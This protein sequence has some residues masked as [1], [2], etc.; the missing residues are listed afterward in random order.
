MPSS[1]PDRVLGSALDCSRRG[2]L[3]ESLATLVGLLAG[4]NTAWA[5]ARSPRAGLLGFA[6]IPPS[7]IDDVVLPPGYVYDI[8][9]A[10]GDPIVPSGPKYDPTARSSAADQARQVGMEHDGM[11]FFPL[12][13]AGTRGLLVVNHEGEDD[14]L[15]HAKGR[16]DWTLEQ[17]RKGQAAVGVS[18]VEIERNGTT[19]KWAVVESPLA[20]RLTANTECELTGPARGAAPVKSPQ[21]PEGDRS[22]G[23]LANCAHGVTPWG[24]YLT[25]EENFHEYYTHSGA[26][27]EMERRYG[28]GDKLI[29]NWHHGDDRFDAAKSPWSANTF[30]WV[31][32]FDP[33]RPDLAP[34]KRTA[35][36][37]FRHENCAITLA[38]DGRVVAYMG[39]DAR[40]EYLYK[41]VSE[42]AG[43]AGQDAYLDSPLD[44]GT[45]YVAR[46][47]GNDVGEWIPLVHGQ[48]GLDA[49]HGFRDQA[50]VCIFA[51][52]AA[53]L[54]LGDDGV[55][56]GTRLDRPEWVAIH[57]KRGEVF[58]SLTNNHER[59]MPGAPDK[60]V[61]AANPRAANQMG[62]IVRFTESEGDAAS[63]HFRW[64]HFLLAGDR[65]HPDPAR[66]G[67]I[68]SSRADQDFAS[69]DGLWVDPRGVLWIQTDVSTDIVGRGDQ[70]PFGNN[71]MLAAD[72]ATGEVRRFLVGPRGCEVT[73]VTCSPD[74]TTLFVNIQHPGQAPNDQ[75]NDPRHVDL[76]SSWPTL[77][78]G[79]RPR[80]ATLAIRRLD[81]GVV[82]AG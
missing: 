30:G 41:F 52:R 32:E 8:V 9:H 44:R 50:D 82:G 79:S 62:Q 39:D 7:T 55:A 24:T 38:K 4:P 47:H 63:T 14:G 28:I 5:R 69:P 16:E 25:C 67:N 54:V 81:G 46:F 53:D 21:F 73:G 71:Q 37:R 61:D 17:V 22:I 1:H 12:D 6:A 19:G 26:M 78:P 34:R 43:T 72:P 33:K 42:R 56:G 75:P 45:L 51:R 2:V 68:R 48:R 80:S 10:W 23:T 20:R 76:H 29:R 58:V 77:T 74:L 31:V 66:R 70:K 27:N 15:L 60:A 64:S 13:E 3:K 36:G 59:G 57:P 65:R 11:H 18:V 40:F 49:E 35:L